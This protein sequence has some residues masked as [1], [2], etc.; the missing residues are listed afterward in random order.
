MVSKLCSTLAD[1]TRVAVTSPHFPATLAR[2][3][4]SFP[5]SIKWIN[6]INHSP[7][8]LIKIRIKRLKY[9][10]HQHMSGADR[11]VTRPLGSGVSSVPLWRLIE[12]MIVW[13]FGRELFGR[14]E[15]LLAAQRLFLSRAGRNAR[16]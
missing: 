3:P 8:R 4:N 13:E 1:A 2:A 5:K 14:A 10:Q 9:V 7:Y 12:L 11:Y 15:L 6:K 16:F